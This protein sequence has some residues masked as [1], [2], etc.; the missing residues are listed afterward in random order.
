MCSFEKLPW[1]MEY[2]LFSPVPK[3]ASS[4]CSF[5]IS[6]DGQLDETILAESLSDSESLPS[7]KLGRK[8]VSSSGVY[9]VKIWFPNGCSLE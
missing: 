9:H 8:K 1:N 5:T 6:Q 7:N 4:N 3:V 2:S